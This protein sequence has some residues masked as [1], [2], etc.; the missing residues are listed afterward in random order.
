MWL[1]VGVVVKPSVKPDIEVVGSKGAA[2]TLA[3]TF[4]SEFVWV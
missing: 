2:W 3:D 4:L 1:V